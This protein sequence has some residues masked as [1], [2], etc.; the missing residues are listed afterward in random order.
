MYRGAQKCLL[1]GTRAARNRMVSAAPNRNP[2]PST[3]FSASPMA[4]QGRAPRRTTPL[5]LVVASVAALICIL[6]IGLATGAAKGGG[7]VIGKTKHT[8]NPNCPSPSGD[9]NPEK[10]CRVSGRVTGFQTMADGRKN[11]FKVRQNGKLVAWSVS[12]SHPN[13]AERKFFEEELSKSGPPSARLS[14][15][16]PR[17]NDRYKLVRQS[18]VVQLKP[19]L[20][21]RPVFTMVDPLRVKKG[22]IVA[23]TTPTWMPNL[24]DFGASQSDRWVASRK[25]GECS[26]EE[27]LLQRSKPQQKVK[28]TR[29][30]G[31]AYRG[32]RL[33]Y[34]A[35]LRP[36]GGGGGGGGGN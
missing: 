23:I 17:G 3:V 7:K 29:S 12:L 33:L 28:G 20:G 18:P 25:K 14:V 30:Y 13:K 9:P 4:S 31:C 19:W 35:W 32:A 1:A 26:S 10:L 21:N 15:L 2:A 5:V 8:P 6:P 36:S 22:E 16:K 24:A 34:W 27:D 11:P